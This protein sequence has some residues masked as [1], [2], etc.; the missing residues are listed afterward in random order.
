[1]QRILVSISSNEG[2]PTD[3]IFAWL[4]VRFDEIKVETEISALGRCEQNYFPGENISEHEKR[5]RRRRRRREEV[6]NKSTDKI[7]ISARENEFRTTNWSTCNR[8]HSTSASNIRIFPLLH[9]CSSV[10]RRRAHT[11]T[12]THAYAH[13][14]ICAESEHLRSLIHTIFHISTIFFCVVN[15]MH[16]LWLSGHACQNEHRKKQAKKIERKEE[17]KKKKRRRKRYAEG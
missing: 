10:G 17:R 15:Q 11:N 14:L 13:E 5:K 1:M 3:D 4:F 8:L 9:M 2:R 6:A 7:V 16:Q 12:L